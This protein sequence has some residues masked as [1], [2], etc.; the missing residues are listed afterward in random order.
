M[1]GNWWTMF[2]ELEIGNKKS[3]TDY[4]NSNSDR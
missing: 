3:V 1:Y 4:V 2:E